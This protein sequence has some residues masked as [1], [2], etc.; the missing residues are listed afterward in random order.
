MS[1]RCNVAILLKEEDKGKE[2]NVNGNSFYIYEDVNYLCIYIHHD[3]Y[4]SGV[5]HNLLFNLKTYDDA[6]KFIL[7]GDRTS[8]DTS[9]VDLGEDYESNEPIQVV[10]E[11]IDEIPNEYLYVFSP[12]VDR[13]GVAKNNGDGKVNFEP[14]K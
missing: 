3:G 2:F 11:T 14:L 7:E 5:G 10:Q 4:L 8:F 13:W 1:T 6:L 9:Y 12:L